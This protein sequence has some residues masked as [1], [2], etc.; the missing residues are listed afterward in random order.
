MMS[1]I[2][3]VIFAVT[4]FFVQI[5]LAEEADPVFA[6]ARDY[7]IKKSD[8]DRII[9]YYSPDRQKFLKDNPKQV[10]SLVK[11]MLEVKAISDIAKKEGFDKRP[12]IAEQLQLTVNNFI[13]SEYIAK[14]VVKDI[15]VTD[16]DVEQYY[17]INKDKF[18][19]PKQV[20]AR[21]ILIKA[22]SSATDE[23]KKKAKAKAEEI[24]E[25]L[26]KGEDFAKLAGEYSE[27]P[28]SRTKGGD[29][30][31]F[32]RGAMV[33]PF[34]DAAFAMKPG[35]TSGVVE[36]SFGYHIIKV[37]D[38]KEAQTKPF[39]EIKTK[40][41]EQLTNEMKKEKGIAFLDKALKEAGSEIYEDT[42]VG[43]AAEKTTGVK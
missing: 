4:V 18:T 30:G 1:K 6:R 33:K 25:Q 35:E 19:V 28:G 27:D 42:I 3:S 32:A 8:M 16:K 20:H 29:L 41:T 22:E 21:H 38:I 7:V 17:E 10:A 26:R 40:L 36:T 43:P 12:D 31:Y 34:E 23:E 14:V 37:E 11:R 9:S 15:S 2:L 24:L 39:A 5:A 13:A